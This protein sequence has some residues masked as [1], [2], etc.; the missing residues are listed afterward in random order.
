MTTIVRAGAPPFSSSASNVTGEEGSP[1]LS[2]T[3]EFPS[4]VGA[5][6]RGCDERRL[7]A[8]DCGRARTIRDSLLEA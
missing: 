6:C 3:R 8:S 7:P 4:T 1:V 2:D 5:A